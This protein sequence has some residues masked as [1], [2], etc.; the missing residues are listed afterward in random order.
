IQAIYKIHKDDFEMRL[1]DYIETFDCSDYINRPLRK[2]SLG[3]RVKVD[4][5]AALIHNPK[6]LF[7]D[8]PFIGLDFKAKKI[9]IEKLDYI[10]RQNKMTCLLTSH[11]IEDIDMLCDRISVIDDGRL[12]SNTSKMDLINSFDGNY[13]IEIKKNNDKELIINNDS[14]KISIMGT[15]YNDNKTI[16]ELKIRCDGKNHNQIIS[17]IFRDNED[18]ISVV[19][20]KNGLQEAIEEKILKS[21]VEY[22]K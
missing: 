7:L 10:I 16:I 20:D 6:I 3:Q 18:I 17:N 14:E 21:K 19:I 12:V 2:L 11:N 13:K 4:I 5:I 15:M 22:F 1:K 9:I 8:E